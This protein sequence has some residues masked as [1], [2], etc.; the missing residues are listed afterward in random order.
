MIELIGITQHYSVR[1][2]LRDITL[3]LESGGVTAIVGPNGMGKSTLLGVMA[4]TLSPQR[5]EVKINGL[6]RRGIMEEELEIRRQVAYLPD[7]PWLPKNRTG[8]EFL[9]GVGKLYSI[10]E[11]RLLDH[12]DRLLQLF[13]LEREGDWPIRSYSHG[14]K[15][16]IALAATL[17]TD[18]PILLLD[19]PFG[20]G[21]DPSGI[22]ALKEVLKRLARIPNRTIVM[23][24]PDP[25]LVEELA[26][27]ILVLREGRIA[28][29]DTAEGLRKLA[30]EGGALTDVIG[31]LTF[32]EALGAVENYFSE[33]PR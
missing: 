20:G 12:A 25:S 18:C 19:E 5:G 22:L 32:P 10:D 21:L 23:T 7:Q 3:K 30:G 11:A 13:Q 27:H 4:G 14:Q 2:V 9:F 1:P 33:E 28:A 17:I 24:A 29:F 31:R 15:K 26:Q 8:R 6:V 16:K